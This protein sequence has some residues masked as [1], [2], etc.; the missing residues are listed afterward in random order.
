MN[1]ADTQVQYVEM[2]PVIVLGP[3]TQK[4]NVNWVCVYTR[5]LGNKHYRGIKCTFFNIIEI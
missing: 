2:A 1:V 4:T 5:I 3:L